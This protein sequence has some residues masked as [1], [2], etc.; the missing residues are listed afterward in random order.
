MGSI[1]GLKQTGKK[2]QG[3]GLQRR[4]S[5]TGKMKTRALRRRTSRKCKKQRKKEKKKSA[6]AAPQQ[7]LAKNRKWGPNQ[8]KNR[9]KGV[10]GKQKGEG[11][12]GRGGHRKSAVKQNCWCPGV[13]CAGKAAHPKEKK[14]VQGKINTNPS[15]DDGQNIRRANSFQSTQFKGGGISKK[16]KRKDLV[17]KKKKTE[18]RVTSVF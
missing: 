13:R 8:R 2:E 5:K 18:G 6:C 16:K 7:I 4:G 9:R 14:N 15:A 17:R 12:V 1:R 10:W 11:E 3:K